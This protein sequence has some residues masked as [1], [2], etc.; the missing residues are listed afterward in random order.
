[1]QRLDLGILFAYVAFNVLVVFA[2]MAL[3]YVSLPK[4]GGKGKKSGKQDKDKSGQQNKE[5][6]QEE[7]SAR[8]EIV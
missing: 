2:F 4:L 5:F 3:R 7:K 6:K 1:M 8:G